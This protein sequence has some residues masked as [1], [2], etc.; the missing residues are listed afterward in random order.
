MD[1][2][3][4][5][6]R[7]LTGFVAIFAAA[8]ILI[9]PSAANALVAMTPVSI[10]AYGSD[11]VYASATMS[12][13]GRYVVFDSA[14]ATLVP[15]DTNN[16]SDIFRKDMQTGEIIR[17][18][19]SSS[20]AESNDYSSNASISADGRYVSF[21]SAASNLV[22]DDIN[23]VTD[24]FLKDIQTGIL[25]RL[26]ASGAGVE[27]NNYSGNDS[28]GVII[29]GN[30]RY[31]VFASNASNLVPDDTNN[32]EDIFKK[33]TQT[34]DIT[35]VNT[36]SSGGQSVYT[37]LGS[38]LNFPSISITPDAR[39]I[40]FESRANDLVAGD[41]NGE[42]L[43]IFVK[44]TNTGAIVRANT[45]SS[46]AQA[47]SFNFGRSTAISA[48]GRYVAFSSCSTVLVPG[49]GEDCGIFRKD[50]QT[51]EIIFVATNAD[52]VEA[53]DYSVFDQNGLTS[54]HPMSA[55]GR[56]VVFQSPATNLVSSDTSNDWDIFV[57]DLAT[58]EVAILTTESDWSSSA[59]V[60]TDG[61]YIAFISSDTDLVSNDTNGLYDIF[62]RA[63][64]FALILP[65]VTLTDSTLTNS[66]MSGATK[67]GSTASP[68]DYVLSIVDDGGLVGVGINSDATL[69]MPNSYNAG[70]YRVTYQAC[71]VTLPS[72]C[73]SGILNVNVSAKTASQNTPPTNTTPPANTADDTLADTGSKMF[74]NIILGAAIAGVSIVIMK[75]GRHKV[76]RHFSVK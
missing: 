55:D 29:S 34:G 20:G 41:T 72:N 17:V 6:V 24:V 63:N 2:R 12:A 3:K 75:F 62:Y 37:G 31:V 16:Q 68:V 35:R 5:S 48:D 36:S 7:N 42:V 40:V 61:R 26:S 13:D 43:D 11:V 45:S 74:A 73:W 67:N 47:E 21:A 66:A 33:D 9:L 1:T 60:S 22:P 15:G 50:L 59:V 32:Q 46:G 38:G 76:Y 27:G 49:F 53:N 19:I 58:G 44:D 4:S 39:Y 56:F 10:V 65:E 25:T 52:G 28:G 69:K 70:N 64:P 57:K 30:G 18:S 8:L 51:G 71:Q 14:T 54:G 23:E